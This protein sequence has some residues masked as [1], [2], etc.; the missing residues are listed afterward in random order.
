MGFSIS[1]IAKN[2]QFFRFA[3]LLRVFDRGAGPKS[4]APPIKNTRALPNEK[5]ERFVAFF[6]VL[7]R[8]CVNMFWEGVT[9]GILRR[10]AAYYLFSCFVCRSAWV[11]GPLCG[12]LTT[13]H[14]RGCHPVTPL[15]YGPRL[16]YLFP[17]SLR[18]GLKQIESRGEY[19]LLTLSSLV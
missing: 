9:R 13:P 14:P 1:L 5:T 12:P 17:T 16:G 3:A 6:P 19:T 15:S 4:P 7:R 2:A 8:C 10:A 18:S 11:R